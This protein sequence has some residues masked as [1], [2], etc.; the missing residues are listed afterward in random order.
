MGGNDDNGNID[1]TKILTEKSSGDR[2][3]A[4]SRLR[5]RR[6]STPTGE[7][8]NEIGSDKEVSS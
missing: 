1:N 4:I 5:H 3:A 6:Q 2:R 7:T 8:E